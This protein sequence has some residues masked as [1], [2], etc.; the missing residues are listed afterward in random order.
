MRKALDEEHRMVQLNGM[1]GIGKSTI[2]ETYIYKYY[3]S[4]DH[5]VWINVKESLIESFCNDNILCKKLEISTQDISLKELFIN[6][7]S[8]LKDIESSSC[9]LVLDNASEQDEEYYKFLPAPPNWHVLL[10][11]RKNI[12]SFN[13]IKIDHLS[14]TEAISLF[15][16]LCPH[17]S[18]DK[19][20]SN[21]LNNIEYHTLTIEILAKTASSQNKSL[22]E[23]THMINDNIL[24]DIKVFHSESSSVDRI[25]DYLIK[26]FRIGNLEPGEKK[27]LQYFICLPLEP[28][29]YPILSNL[30]DSHNDNDANHQKS[31]RKLSQKGWLQKSNKNEF[32]IHRLI[33][34]V[35]LREISPKIDDIN[36]LLVRIISNLEF[37]EFKEDPSIKFKWI[38]FGRSILSIFKEKN[39]SKL[40]NLR[41]NLAIILRQYGDYNGAKAL[42][43]TILNHHRSSIDSQNINIAL[44]SAKYA[45]VLQNL[46]EY[47]QAKNLLETLLIDLKDEFGDCHPI[48]MEHNAYLASI[49]HDK[50]DFIESRNLFE[51]VIAFGIK[52]FNKND[53]KTINHKSNFG[54]LLM[55]INEKNKSKELLA[56]VLEEQ[57]KIYEEFSIPV[58]KARYHLGI[59]L[60]RNEELENARAQLDKAKEIFNSILGELHPATV[61]SSSMLAI[62]L[63]NLKRFDEAESLLIRA[64][65][66]DKKKY[67]EN[68]ISTINRYNAYANLLTGIEKYDEAEKYLL[69]VN[70]A[71]LK[72]YGK[73]HRYTALGYINLASV[74]DKKK[75]HKEAKRIL[76]KTL[77][78]WITILP[79]D[80]E[81]IEKI[82]KKIVNLDK[83]IKE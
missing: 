78:I 1:G 80:F 40:T 8:G 43:E 13:S 79:N 51:E 38:S 64:I 63:T 3:N 19:G 6:I 7:V 41:K 73:Y 56:N 53:P 5:I 76:E 22:K 61:Q 17:I 37:D 54:L 48:V 23:L 39:H 4:Y 55:D 58:A 81:F 57:L 62:N 31:L 34:L 30:I 71:D 36:S 67:G 29:A 49:L 68:H 25:L 35:I 83:L 46:G 52:T 18:D 50:S 72:N 26:I 74:L 24:A 65:E 42:W 2:A 77:D 66:I 82:N 9:L 14:N 12:F 70:S 11:S 28:I 16:E 59:L 44:D 21:L 60:N 10:T 75:K 27:I 32:R 15:K 69:K 47:D 20:I 45:L 33:A